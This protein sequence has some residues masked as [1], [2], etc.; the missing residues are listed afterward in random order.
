[1]KTSIYSTAFR[2]QGNTSFNVIG[3]LSN[4]AM[5]ADEISIACGDEPSAQ[6]VEDAARY[7]GYPVKITRTSIDFTNDP[8]AYGKTENAAL[9]HAAR[10]ALPRCK[11]V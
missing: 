3:A 4:W 5:Y 1:M 9:R 6:R 8:F 11:R 7:G 2:L 10:R